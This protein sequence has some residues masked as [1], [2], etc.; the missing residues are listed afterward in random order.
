MLKGK[1]QINV[2]STVTTFPLRTS[3]DVCHRA[4]RAKACKWGKI[5][6]EFRVVKVDRIKNPQNPGGNGLLIWRSKHA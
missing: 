5:K 4:Q 2:N 3:E 1:Q 6:L